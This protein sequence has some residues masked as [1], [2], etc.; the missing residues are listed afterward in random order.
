MPLLDD[1]VRVDRVANVDVEPERGPPPYEILEGSTGH[2][3]AKIFGPYINA[4]LTSLTVEDPYLHER[5]QCEHFF[6]LC[7]RYECFHETIPETT[8]GDFIKNIQMQ[9]FSV[10]G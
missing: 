1:S 8:F 9:A 6:Y 10:D 5:Y 2:T 7:E 4:S 3:Y